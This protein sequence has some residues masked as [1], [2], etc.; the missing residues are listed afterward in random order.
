[1]DSLKEISEKQRDLKKKLK[2]SFVGEPGNA[3]FQT[4]TLRLVFG[5]NSYFPFIITY[6]SKFHRI[7]NKSVLPSLMEVSTMR[8]N[9]IFY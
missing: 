3:V 7:K 4:R 9:V 5:L 8:H 1:M 2:V 6:H